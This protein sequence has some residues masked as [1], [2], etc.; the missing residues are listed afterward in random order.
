[1]TAMR[2]LKQLP[3][4]AWVADAKLDEKQPDDKCVRV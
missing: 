4:N 3:L 1:M 2:D